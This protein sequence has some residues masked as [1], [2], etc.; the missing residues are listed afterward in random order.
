MLRNPRWRQEGYGEQLREDFSR[1]CLSVSLLTVAICV[2]MSREYCCGGK[3]CGY[4]QYIGLV[5]CNGFLKVNGWLGR[6]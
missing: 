6:E 2:E 4:R 5:S 1:C 3:L